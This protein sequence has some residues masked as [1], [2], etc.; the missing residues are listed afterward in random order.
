MSGIYKLVFIILICVYYLGLDRLPGLSDRPKLGYTE[1]VLHE[2][3]R[4]SSVVPSGVTHMT[5]CDTEIGKK[6]VIII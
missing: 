6:Y 5:T 2:S 3:M 1:A 4:L